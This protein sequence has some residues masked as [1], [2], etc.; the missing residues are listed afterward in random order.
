MN[1][2]V[3]I[4]DRHYTEWEWSNV[5]TQEKVDC[6]LNPLELTSILGRCS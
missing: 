3:E 5:N 2:K 4:V 1:L 6:D